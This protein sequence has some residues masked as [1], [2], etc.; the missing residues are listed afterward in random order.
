MTKQSENSSLRLFLIDFMVIALLF[1]VFLFLMTVVSIMITGSREDGMGIGVVIGFISGLSVFYYFRGRFN[2]I[3]SL[4]QVLVN[5]VLSSAAIFG[6][7]LLFKNSAVI[8][9]SYG[10]PF[11]AISV[12]AVISINKKIIDN[13]TELLKG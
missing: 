5:M 3:W 7:V 8:D 4:M 11:I 6:I 13:L 1:V 2:F 10:Y 12:P 9:T